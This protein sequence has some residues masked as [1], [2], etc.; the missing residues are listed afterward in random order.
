MKGGMYLVGRQIL[1]IGLKIIG[2]MVITRLLGPAGYGTY[3]SA[4]NIYQYTLMLGQAGVGVYLLRQEAAIS[5]KAYGTAYTMLMAM[6]IILAGAI[7]LARYPLGAWIGVEGFPEVAAIIM[8]ALPFQLM[9]VPATVM[10]ERTLNY[11]SIAF[12]EITGQIFFYV[13]GAPLVM[14]H[15]GPVGLAVAWVTQ[16]A[17]SCISAYVISRTYPKFD[18]DKDVAK[19]IFTYAAG[20]SFA[21]WI[22]QLRMLVNPLVVGPALGAQSVGLVGMAIGLLE[23]LSIIKTIAWRLSVAILA[24]FQNDAAKLRLAIREGMEL[25][26]LAIGSSLVGFAWLGGILVPWFF[27]ARWA[28]VMDIYPYIALGYFTNAM[29]NMHSSVLSLLRRNMRVAVF[30]T[31]HVCLF[32]GVAAVLVPRIGMIGYG[33]GEVVALL[34]YVV[35]HYFTAR[36]VGSPNYNPTFIWW[37]GIAIGLFWRD[38]GIWAIAAPFVALAIPPSPSRVIFY[39]HKIRGR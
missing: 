28:P 22:W 23:M 4:F 9:A 33:I 26:A 15:F 35:I 18:F 11:Q 31:V 12:L 5:D 39:Y 19:A 36:A 25:Q 27:G 38:L 16:Q 37:I 21:N 20:Y 7:E 8:L 13:V 6:T 30:H 10:I 3:V 1:S 32:A 29:F 2:V 14:L 17:I 24:R 34:S